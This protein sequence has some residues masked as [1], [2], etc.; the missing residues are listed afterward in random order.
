MMDIVANFGAS[1]DIHWFS[2]HKAL[3]KKLNTH[4]RYRAQCFDKSQSIAYLYISTSLEWNAAYA[5]E[6]SKS[7]KKKR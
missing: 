4:Y 1:S 2:D 5:S 7:L 6:G 3:E